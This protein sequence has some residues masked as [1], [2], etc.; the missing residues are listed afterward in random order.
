MDRVYLKPNAIAEPLINQWY[1]WSYLIPPATAAMYMAN[2]Q[3]KIMESFV[4]D[5][6]VHQMALQNPAMIGGPFINYEASRVSEIADLLNYTKIEQSKLFEL[7][8][9]I[10]ELENILQEQANGYSLEPLYEKVPEALKGY[11][12]LVYDTHNNPSI[13]FIEGLLYRSPEY[14]TPHQTM[15]LSVKDGDARSF[16]LSTPRLPDEG[17]LELKRPFNDSAWYRL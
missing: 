10:K 13:R 12:E 2:S 14:Q 1:A 17:T 7:A 4:E 3:I 16:V 11:V 5:P 15:A 8:A 9:A 6:K